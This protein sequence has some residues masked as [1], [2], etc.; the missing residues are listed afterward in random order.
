MSS[1]EEP[2]VYAQE[3]GARTIAE[4]TIVQS[5]KQFWVSVWQYGQL[6]EVH[7]I[8]FPNTTV[9][10]NLGH[11]VGVEGYTKYVE[12]MRTGLSEIRVS[13]EFC[14]V[15]EN[16]VVMHWHLMGLH[17]GEWLGH[18]AT[19]KPISVSCVSRIMYYDNQILEEI[20]QWDVF[21]VSTQLGEVP[22]DLQ[23]KITGDDIVGQVVPGSTEA[24]ASTED[25]TAEAPAEGDTPPP[26]EG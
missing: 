17:T 14:V 5:I 15:E 13:I 26:A 22:K 10:S 23:A 7:T 25:L 6:E 3:S 12:M 8:V 20:D 18:P 1:V 19:G 9:N 2:A 24:D 21:G 4:S 16:S 11:F